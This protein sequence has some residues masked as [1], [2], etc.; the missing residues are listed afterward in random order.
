MKAPVV[1]IEIKDG[2]LYRVTSTEEILVKVV[3]HDS[4][5]IVE[6]NGTQTI[7]PPIGYR[8]A[9]NLVSEERMGEIINDF[10]NQM[11]C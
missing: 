7:E 2:I 9:N 10:E 4:A 5:D 6:K 1:L 11:G 8:I 3:D